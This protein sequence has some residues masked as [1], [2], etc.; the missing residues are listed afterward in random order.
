MLFP[1][2]EHVAHFLMSPLT[3]CPLH[4]GQTSQGKC[5][6]VTPA[7]DPVND[8]H[9]SQWGVAGGIRSRDMPNRPD[10]SSSNQRS[11]SSVTQGT[12]AIW[13]S[14]GEAGCQLSTWDVSGHL[15][16]SLKKAVRGHCPLLI[17]T[18]K[19]LPAC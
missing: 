2:I 4:R 8:I 3:L 7:F 9:E 13:I 16:T 6:R 5:A 10:N 14:F 17:P 18:F 1:G 12:P 11:P 19:N 15:Y